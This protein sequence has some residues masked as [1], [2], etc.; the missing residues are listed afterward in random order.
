MEKTYRFLGLI[1]ALTL[2][3]AC[4]N[5]GKIPSREAVEDYVAVAELEEMKFIRY[6]RQIHHAHLNDYYAILS[7]RDKYYLAEFGRRCFALTDTSWIEADVRRERGV[8]RA[9]ADTIRGC[10]I[11]A[12][13]ALNKG[14]VD[15]LEALGDAPGD[16]LK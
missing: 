6:R 1:A 16:T 5:Q 9:R 13:Y 7:E 3:G 11:K 8:I 10:H 2:V 15:E 4:A 12:L 14:Q